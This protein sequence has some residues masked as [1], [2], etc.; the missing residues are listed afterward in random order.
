MCAGFMATVLTLYCQCDGLTGLVLPV[1]VV[2][3]LGVVASCVGGHGGQDDQRVVQ[4]D[5][6]G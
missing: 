2:D 1:F 6:S 5:G 3:R 4:G